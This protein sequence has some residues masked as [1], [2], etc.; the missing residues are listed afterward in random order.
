M[1]LE[2]TLGMAAAGLGLAILLTL[3]ITYAPP[4]VAGPDRDA[5]T[6]MVALVNEARA[7]HG[8]GALEPADDV[9]TVAEAWSARM[10]AEDDLQ[11]NPGYG[12]E[13]CCWSRLTE[14][15][16][17]SDPYRLWRPGD[18]VER[19]VSEL[20]ERLLESPGH[21][22]NLLDPYVDQIGIGIHVDTDGSIWITQNFR[23]RSL[24]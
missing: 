24:R 23:Q 8:L 14:N 9:A 21:R 4:A 7:G 18:P 5:A 20:H 3:A 13:I 15:V 10:A 2:R 22:A 16:A 17:F 12:A 6:H 11:H 19:I 1:Q